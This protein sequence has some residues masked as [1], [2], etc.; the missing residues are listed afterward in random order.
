MIYKIT[1]MKSLSLV[2]FLTV[3]SIS[4]A[5]YDVDAGVI[6]IIEVET[7]KDHQALQISF[8]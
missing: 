3:P 6:D 4:V 2:L 8:G 5:A 1:R 7:K